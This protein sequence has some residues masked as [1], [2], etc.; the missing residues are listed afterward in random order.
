MRTTPKPAADTAPPQHP[1]GSTKGAIG[2]G[3]QVLLAS[4]RAYL[5]RLLSSR[6]SEG[7][8]RKVVGGA[9]VARGSHVTTSSFGADYGLKDVEERRKGLRMETPKGSIRASLPG[10]QSDPGGPR[11]PRG[12]QGPDG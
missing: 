5:D 2:G 4:L 11:P 10:R 3:K 8:E 9:I 7:L 6:G 1:A 12:K